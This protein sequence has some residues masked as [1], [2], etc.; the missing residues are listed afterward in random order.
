MAA[1][2]SLAKT[3]EGRAR[4]PWSETEIRRLIDLWSKRDIPEISEELGRNANAISIKASRLGLPSRCRM[5]KK[6]AEAKVNPKARVR[7]CLSCRVPFFSEG[8]HHRICD[9]CKDTAAWRTGSGGHLSWT[10][11]R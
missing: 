2:T 8:A 11:G 1:S 4:G 7:P 5:R 9:K 3:P 10:G 6:E